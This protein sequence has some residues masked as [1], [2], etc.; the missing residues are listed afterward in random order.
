MTPRGTLARPET[1]VWTVHT[2]PGA[3]RS[4]VEIARFRGE[5]L[6]DGGRRPTYRLPDGRCV[7]PDPSDRDAYHVTASTSSGLIGVM[8][9]VPLRATD[10]G[11]CQRLLGS[12]GLGRLLTTVGADRA[13]TW[14]G[15]GWAVEAA[16]RTNGVGLALLAAGTALARRLELRVAIGAAGVRYGQYARIRRAGYRPVPGFDPLPVAKFADEVRM[17]WGADEHLATEFR[18][19]TEMVA[20]QLKWP[21]PSPT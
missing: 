17:V 7:D 20:D 3:E 12:D 16:H 10:Q 5:V 8:R 15:S 9:V 4:L 18:E 19:L 13:S 21:G 2:P 6:Y 1:L 11:V 14:E